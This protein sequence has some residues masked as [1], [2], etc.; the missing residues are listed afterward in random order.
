MSTTPPEVLIYLQSVKLYFE[1][2]DAAR[3]YF[4]DGINEDD[5]FNEVIKISINNFNKNKDPML[6]QSQFESIKYSL[7]NEEYDEN[8]L[9]DIYGLDSNNTIIFI[10]ERNITN[11]NYI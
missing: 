9:N 11:I 4:L 1:K 10:D 5:F 2:N 6:H 7:L 3:E 8:M